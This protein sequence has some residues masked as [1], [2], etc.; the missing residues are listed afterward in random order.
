M[1]LSLV[2]G[3]KLLRRPSCVNMLRSGALVFFFNFFKNVSTLGRGGTFLLRREPLYH[4]LQ[5]S[6]APRF[7]AAAATLGVVLGALVVYLS[8]NGF[9]SM[10]VDLSDLTT[11][12]WYLG[13][14]YTSFFY[15]SWWV[16]A[17]SQLATS[18]GFVGLVFIGEFL[19]AFFFEVRFILFHIT[20]AP[21]T[22]L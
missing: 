16:C 3:I 10:G 6:K 12:V 9:G 22:R 17:S 5:Y 18:C 13:L 14:W 11:L 1:F 21:C 4:K 7:D 15:F 19:V 20:R 2:W 8:L